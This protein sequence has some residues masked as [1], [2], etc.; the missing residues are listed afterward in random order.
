[1]RDGMLLTLNSGIHSL[2]IEFDS[3]G[4]YQ[5]H[6][7]KTSNMIESNIVSDLVDPEKKAIEDLKQLIQEALNKHEFT[8]PPPPPAAPKEEEKKTETEEA[9]APVEE[10]VAA[11][12]APVLVV[13]EEPPKVETSGVVELV[14]APQVVEEKKEG[15]APAPEVEASVA[16][17][18]TEEVV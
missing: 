17:V 11:E 10:K 3:L 13:T 2:E 5:R 12:E 9:P 6:I 4:D 18:V 15:P 1:M 16:A 8:S 14:L 7:N